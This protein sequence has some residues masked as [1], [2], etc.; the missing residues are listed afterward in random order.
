MNDKTN[1]LRIA[2]NL[3]LPHEAVTQTFAI[4]AKRGAGKTYTAL[5][6]VEEIHQAGHQVVVV[7]PVGVAWGLRSSADGKR[8]GLDIIILGGDHGDVPLEVTAGKVVADLVVNDRASL[9]LDLS[10][11]RKNESVRFMTDFAERLYHRNRD[12]LHLLLDEADM[13]APQRAMPGEQRMLGAVEDLVRRGRARGIGVTLVTQRP[14][15][16]NKNVLTQIEVLVALRTMGPQDRKAID[17]WIKVH[18]TPE[19][20]ETLMASLPSLPIGTA[21]FWSP[22]W[23]DIFKK[24]KVRRRTTFD[25]SATPKTGGKV[26]KPKKLAEVDL[27]ALQQ[28]MAA[29]IERAKNEDPKLLRKRIGKLERELQK[30]SGT[31]DIEKAV[32]ERDRFW[33]GEMAKREQLVTKVQVAVHETACAVDR[34]CNINGATPPLYKQEKSAPQTMRS[35]GE[36]TVGYNRPTSPGFD[37]LT[38]AQ[39]KILR[40]FYWLQHEDAT[41]AKVSFYAGYRQSGHFNSSISSLRTAGLITGWQI[42]DAGIALIPADVESKPTG[43]Q[44]REWLRS[45]LSKAENGILDVL[46]DAG[47]VRVSIGDLVERSGYQQSGH[48]NSSLSKLRTLNAAEGFERYGGVKA[49]DVFF[50]EA[51][52]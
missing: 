19:Q 25:S 33:R 45:K 31:V 52:A 27:G 24:V 37:E 3:I 46:V 12:P 17:E 16:L 10:H 29:T 34:L 20:R 23:L 42:T 7:D 38:K 6:M 5:V 26:R 21:W 40:A 50:A 44:L 36:T 11:F 39:Q 32:A 13:F 22:G 1:G 15:V 4:L 43:V 14:A 49:A 9:V 51:V 47:G 2:S 28:Q 18:G 30:A 8:A 41:P 35:H 48:F